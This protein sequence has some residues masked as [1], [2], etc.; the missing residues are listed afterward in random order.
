M[1][2]GTFNTLQAVLQTFQIR[3]QSSEFVQPIP[4]AVNPQLR[5]RLAFFRVNAPTN[6]SEEAVCEF[7]I[8]PVL[9]EIWLLYA[10]ILTLWSH[11]YLGEEPPLKGFP[12]YFFTRRSPLGRVMDQPYVLFI[13]AKREDF[14]QAWA[15]CLAAMLAAQKLN[16]RQE[17]VIHGCVSSGELW[18][19][20]KLTNTVLT[21]DP[22]AYTLTHLEELFAALHYLFEQAKQEVLAQFPEVGHA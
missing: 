10:D 17:Q 16:K 1:A 22:R 2:F 11:A 15:Q 3:V 7:L 9:Q 14:D 20:G 6:V 19:F 4:L 12:D 13:E 21:Q 18:Y 5:E 8:A